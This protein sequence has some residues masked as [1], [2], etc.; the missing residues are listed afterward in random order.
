MR[1][2]QARNHFSDLRGFR[3]R[4]FQKFESDRRVVKQFARHD[5]RALRAGRFRY[6]LDFSPLVDGTCPAFLVDALRRQCQLGYGGNR[7][8]RLTAEPQRMKRKQFMR[9]GNLACR[10]ALKRHSDVAGADAASIIRHTQIS[11]A[12]VTN[13]HGN[14]C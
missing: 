10:V 11:N 4:L 7:S 2:N 6:P 12:A 14:A 13:F 3:R 8:Q 9:F 1:Q 5:G